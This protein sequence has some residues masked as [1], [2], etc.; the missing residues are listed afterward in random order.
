MNDFDIGWV[1]IAF[2]AFL[3]LSIAIG[4]LRGFVF[5]L[6]SLVGWF[7]AFV[8]AMWFEPA[9]LPWVHVGPPGAAA[10]HWIAFGGVF[11]L[12]LIVWSLGARLVR[13]LVR[14]TPLSGIDRLLGAGF[15]VVRGV[16]VLLIAATLIS[17]SPWAQ[18]AAWQQSRGVA[19]LG[20]LMQNLRPYLSEG[21]TRSTTA[22]GAP[23][24]RIGV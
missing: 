8:A 24:D 6:L 18:S 17:L 13:A 5:E 11:L 10:N 15:G 19:W 3:L 14:A 7:A 23:Q 20:V 1:D 4:L 12:S 2:A 22:R 16:V 21:D 9:V